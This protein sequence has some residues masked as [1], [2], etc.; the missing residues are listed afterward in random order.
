[1]V[2]FYLFFGLLLID[3]EFGTY[4]AALKAALG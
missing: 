3:C 2:N 1:M 4:S